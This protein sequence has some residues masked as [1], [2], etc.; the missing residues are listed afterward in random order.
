[1]INFLSIIIII[2]ILLF[3]LIFKKRSILKL[4]NKKNL[5]SS[6]KAYKRQTDI[7]SHSKNK[8][9]SEFEKKALRIEM[10]KLFKGTTAKKLKALK[11]AKIL[12]DKSTLPILRLG[13]KDMEPDIVKFSAN[14]I[15]SF[16]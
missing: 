9:Y 14:L 8:K 12:G 11:I 7:Y 15:R 6:K 3:L 2:L 5:S 16:K 10:I 4:L 1:M 13:L